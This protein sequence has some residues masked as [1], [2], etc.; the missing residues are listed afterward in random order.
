MLPVPYLDEK[1]IFPPVDQALENG[2]LAVGGDLSVERLLLAYKSGIFPWFE[3]GESILWWSPNP[4]FI[5]F[6]D[7]LKVSKSMQQLLHKQ[8]FRVTYNTDFKTVIENCASV[9]RTGQRGTWI[10]KE[11]IEA[12][13]KLHEIGYATSVEVWQ[14]DKLVGGFY[15]V[16]LHQGVFCGESMF[17][18]VPNASKYA[19][20]TF[21]KNSNY[22]L[23]DCQLYTKHLA[24]FGAKLMERADFLTF[25]DASKN[26]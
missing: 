10:T 25:L 3:E 20:I 16:D 12:Y 13:T 15:G 17:T 19:F 24:S 6:P 26:Q 7:E 1:L 2:L 23:I 8:A 5:L 11:M 14:Q 22:R 9:K 4:R 18:L 21:V